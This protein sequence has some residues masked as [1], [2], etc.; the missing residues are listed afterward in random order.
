[1][2]TVPDNSADVMSFPQL[3]NVA[4]GDYSGTVLTFEAAAVRRL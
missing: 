4:P 1:V 2:R 3:R